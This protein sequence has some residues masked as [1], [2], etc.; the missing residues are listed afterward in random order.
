MLC[1]KVL[2]DTI[3][4]HKRKEGVS[5]IKHYN[6]DPLYGTQYVSVHQIPATPTKC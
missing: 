1:L 6:W 3:Y 5:G 2:H 4:G